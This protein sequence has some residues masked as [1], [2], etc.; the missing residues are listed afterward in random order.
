[1]VEMARLTHA[2]RPRFDSGCLCPCPCRQAG[3][4][5][6]ETWNIGDSSRSSATRL[7]LPGASLVDLMMRR[8]MTRAMRMRTMTMKIT[9]TTIAIRIWEWT[10]RHWRCRVLVASSRGSCFFFSGSVIMASWEN[11]I[12]KAQNAQQPCKVWSLGPKTLKYESLEP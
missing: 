4:I 1:M 3:G 5:A 8:R 12:P 2:A 11:D 7:P 9:M 10:D 6:T